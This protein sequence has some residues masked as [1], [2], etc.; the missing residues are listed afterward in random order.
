M[1]I[2]SSYVRPV[3]SKGIRHDIVWYTPDLHPID[4]R[5]NQGEQFVMMTKDGHAL[6]HLA[7]LL[8]HQGS[9]VSLFEPYEF[10]ESTHFQEFDTVITVGSRLSNPITDRVLRDELS[11]VDPGRIAFEFS[12]FGLGKDAIVCR[13]GTENRRKKLVLS[14]E[15][16]FGAIVSFVGGQTHFLVLAGLGPLGALATCRHLA[17]NY[18]DLDKQFAHWRFFRVL[19]VPRRSIHSAIRVCA[20]GVIGSGLVAYPKGPPAG[21][22]GSK[23]K[24]R[25]VTK[26]ATSV[27]KP[28]QPEPGSRRSSGKLAARKG[29]A[30][31]AGA[32]ELN[33]E[34]ARADQ[35]VEWLANLELIDLSIQ[36]VMG[37]YVCDD[38]DERATLQQ[39]V[40]KLRT[41]MKSLTTPY[42]VLLSGLPGVGKTFFVQEFARLIGKSLIT[43]NLSD[44]TNIKSALASHFLDI[45]NTVS[46][47]HIAFLDEVDTR[48]NGDA[49]Y[50]FLLKAMRGDEVEVNHALKTKLPGVMWFFAGSIGTSAA[51]WQAKAKQ[52]GDQKVDD[53]FRTFGEKG[54]TIDLPALST[55]KERVIR[56]AAMAKGARPDLE[57]IESRALLYFARSKWGDSGELKAAVSAG[58]EQMPGSILRFADVTHDKTLVEFVGT[59]TAPMK[60]LGIRQVKIL[61]PVR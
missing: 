38:K 13:T 59:H 52:L 48:V 44:V 18:D 28:R 61:A 19:R 4:F 10:Q 24:R 9:T 1:A 17:D 5:Y 40:D 3:C 11:K 50:R 23:T 30:A 34:P 49:A 53:F 26:G 14:Q 46:P 36:A 25:P 7:W 45:L 32:K 16:D 12:E 56:A 47:P 35:T 29:R 58:I 43:W 57:W 33:S 6:A 51:E 27:L 2:V 22:Q 8:G 54:K 41:R 21:L 31:E 55:E 42:P 39:H 60:S 37:K 20:E 15:H